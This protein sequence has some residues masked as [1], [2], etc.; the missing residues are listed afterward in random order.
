MDVIVNNLS[1]MWVNEIVSTFWIQQYDE[2][3]FF[4]KPFDIHDLWGSNFW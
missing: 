2:D 1:H 3:A 4:K